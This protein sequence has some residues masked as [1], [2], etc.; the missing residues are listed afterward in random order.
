MIDKIYNPL[1]EP[2]VL[3]MKRS[4][5][6]ALSAYKYA[7]GGD[8]HYRTIEEMAG[9]FGVSEIFVTDVVGQL[10]GLHC[11]AMIP[12]GYWYKEKKSLNVSWQDFAENRLNYMKEK[13]VGG[14]IHDLLSTAVL[15]EA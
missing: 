5:L 8:T 2:I 1:G 14:K 7:A 15:K 10:A 3:T 6:T 13:N 9:Q 4:L 11:I 12:T